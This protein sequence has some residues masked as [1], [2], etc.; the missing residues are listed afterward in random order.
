MSVLFTFDTDFIKT[1]GKTGMNKLIQLTK[2]N[3]DSKTLK[4]LIGTTI[5]LTGTARKYNKAFSYSGAAIVPKGAM[6]RGSKG[7]W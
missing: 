3:L 5:K 2:K 1:Y 6:C 7:D 4:N